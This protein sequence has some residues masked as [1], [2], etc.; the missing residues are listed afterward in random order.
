MIKNT[1]LKKKIISAVMLG[2]LAVS[3]PACG[4]KQPEASTT[5]EEG[6]E[7]TVVFTYGNNVV[8]KGEVYIYI[9]TVK[10]RYELQY[11]KDVWNVTIEEGLDQNVT[12]AGLTKQEVVE[13]IVRV[14]TLAAHAEEMGVSLSVNDTEEIDKKVTEFYEGLTDDDKKRME[15]D[16]EKIRR[17][18]EETAIAK[19]VEDKILEKNPVEVSSE[20]ARMTRFYDM[21]FPCYSIDEKGNVT[22]YSDTQREKQYKNALQAAST[23]ATA[24]LSDDDDAKDV[25]KLA[26]YYKLDQAKEQVLS[27]NEIFETY[28]E[29]IFNLLYSMENGAYSEVIE[30]EYGYH[31][32]VMYELTDRE[33]TEEKKQRLKSERITEELSETLEKWRTEIDPEF[34]YPDS[35]DMEVYD[36]IFNG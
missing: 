32:F 9:N 18:Y 12:M 8:T 5:V 30:S 36:S 19:E 28:G 23:L 15:L 14:K 27:P 22:S 6:V 11:G 31:V 29:D 3:V 20:E 4:A 1:L 25:E 17:V 13:E 34:K 16:E 33:K 7:K 24:S 21:Y 2:I 35:V 26:E 10:E